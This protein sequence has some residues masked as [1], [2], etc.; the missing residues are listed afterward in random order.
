MKK[1]LLPIILL[2][3][4]V[5]TSSCKKAIEKVI[6]EKQEDYVIL[7]MTN[8][9]WKMSWFKEDSLLVND[10]NGFEFKYYADYTVDGIDPNGI[11]KKGIWSG[12][13]ATLTTTTNFPASANA[14]LTK[15]NGSWKITKNSWTFVEAEQIVGNF[16]KTMRLDKK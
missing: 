14:P 2:F 11:I 5:A 8:G 9:I 3:I 1:N 12:N 6:E 4:I 16:K 15:L 7:A 10:F 13:G